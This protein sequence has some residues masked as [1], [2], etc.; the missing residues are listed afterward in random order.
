MTIFN[1]ASRA[2]QSTTP[3]W[4]AIL[5]H[6]TSPNPHYPRNRLTDTLH[7]LYRACRCE[8]GIARIIFSF[9][10]NPRKK[11]STSL[12]STWTRLREE[13]SRR[14]QARERF[15]SFD[16]FR[17]LIAFSKLRKRIAHIR[18]VSVFLTRHVNL[19]NWSD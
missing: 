16:I 1:H 11:W 9:L 8:S 6:A 4:R 13:S 14:Y 19:L 18:T 7:P 2:R 3:R 10:R 12:L 5:V 17:R 15:V